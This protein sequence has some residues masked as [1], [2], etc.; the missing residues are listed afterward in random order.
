[1]FLPG[2][3]VRFIGP[4]YEPVGQN[5]P[6]VGQKGIV[7]HPKSGYFASMPGGYPKELILV[8]FDRDKNATFVD[9]NRIEKV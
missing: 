6:A 3:W 1:M 4:P 7:L 8:L 5:G 9:V 2:D